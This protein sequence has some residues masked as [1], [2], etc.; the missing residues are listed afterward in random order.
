MYGRPAPVG[1]GGSGPNQTSGRA[2]RSAGVGTALGVGDGAATDARTDADG[3][4]AADSSGGADEQEATVIA[5]AMAP[6]SRR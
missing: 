3:K 5:T 6:A 4:I 2:E 1:S